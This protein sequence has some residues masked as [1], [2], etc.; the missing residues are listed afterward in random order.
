[1]ADLGSGGTTLSFGAVDQTPVRSMTYNETSNEHDITDLAKSQHTFIA[2]IATFELTIEIIGNTTMERGDTG[3]IAIAWND[4]TSDNG[5]GAKF[6][7]TSKEVSAEVDS[8][9]TS[10]LTF[11]PTLT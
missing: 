1:M 6:L 10:S 11:V 9:I 8:E 4:G 5:G 7:I 3:V 2:G